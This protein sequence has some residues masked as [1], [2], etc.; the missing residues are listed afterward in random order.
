MHAIF[1]KLSVFMGLF[2][3][4]KDVS[5]G[6]I[7]LIQGQNSVEKVVIVCVGHLCGGL[8]ILNT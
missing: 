1:M 6:L 2:T 3:S 7:Q 5:T 4:T 8:D